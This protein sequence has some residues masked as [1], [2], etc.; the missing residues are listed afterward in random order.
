MK[1]IA[2]MIVFLM[3]AVSAFAD[4]RYTVVN[5]VKV[6]TE[7]ISTASGWTDGGSTSGTRNVTLTLPAGAIPLAWRAT[8][9]TAIDADTSATLLVGVTGDTNKF[10]ESGG[11]DIDTVGVYG[12]SAIGQTEGV[13]AISSAQTILLTL[14]EDSDFGDITAGSFLFEF[15]YI[16]P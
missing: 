4:D 7:T 12:D 1:K 8:T 16:R 9:T 13:D 5:P 14:T 2:L 15:F 3:I 6:I 10:S 11:Q